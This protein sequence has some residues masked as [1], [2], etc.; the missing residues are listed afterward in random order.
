[1]TADLGD[2]V[3]LHGDFTDSNGAYQN[4]TTVTLYLRKP[5]KQVTTHT[6]GTD[7]A[8]VRSETGKYHYDLNANA[9]GWWYYRWVS[10]GT[11]Q[12]AGEESL[13]VKTPKAIP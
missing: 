13:L 11:C 5:D 7:V 2:L 1:M 10:T 8:V 6:Y 9:P 12:A 3:R 4:P